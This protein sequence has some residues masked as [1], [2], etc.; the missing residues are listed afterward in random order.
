MSNVDQ[1]MSAS[2]AVMGTSTAIASAIDTIFKKE[3]AVITQS[4]AAKITHR[5]AEAA[6]FPVEMWD[7]LADILLSIDRLECCGAFKSP[8]EI[9]GVL[10]DVGTLRHRLAASPSAQFLHDC[11]RRADDLMFQA[12]LHLLIACHASVRRAACIADAVRSSSAAVPNMDLPLESKIEETISEIDALGR[13]LCVDMANVVKDNIKPALLQY[14]TAAQAAA[15][16]LPVSAKKFAQQLYNAGLSSEVFM[17]DHMV[18]LC[19]TVGVY[20]IE[21][22]RHLDDAEVQEIMTLMQLTPVQ[23]RK[24]LKALSVLDETSP[25]KVPKL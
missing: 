8:R 1:Q 16:A 19:G 22:F 14:I 4:W 2:H 9:H 15:A 13:Y 18:D 11:H 10:L 17:L 6:L 20:L 21:D 24:L 7:N 25:S 3:A 23:Q 5:T 12:Q